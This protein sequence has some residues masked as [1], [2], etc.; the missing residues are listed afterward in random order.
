MPKRDPKKFSA[1]VGQFNTQLEEQ[2]R[3][4]D[5]NLRTFCPQESPRELFK[6][7]RK[8]VE[9]LYLAAPHDTS[10]WTQ[11]TTKENNA[12]KFFRAVVGENV[13]TAL[14]RFL[15]ILINMNVNADSEGWSRFQCLCLNG[16][17]AIT[18]RDL[19]LDDKTIEKILGAR[20]VY[21]FRE[22]Q[23]TFSP[24]V[25][26]MNKMLDCSDERYKGCRLPY[27]NDDH[28]IGGGAYGR[29][30]SVKIAKRHI[31][32]CGRNDEDLELARKDFEISNEGGNEQGD[33]NREWEVT[34]NFITSGYKHDHIMNS[35]FS[36]KMPKTFSIFY[37]KA[38]CNLAEFMSNDDNKPPNFQQK[39]QQLIE[40]TCM[41][42]GLECLHTKLTSRDRQRICCY[43]L[44]LKPQNIL[45]IRN[46]LCED[47]PTDDRAI[48]F[49][50]ADFSISKIVYGQGKSSTEYS[51]TRM[52]KGRNSNYTVES[53]LRDV[54]TQSRLGGNAACIPPE[55]MNPGRVNAS[56]DIWGLGCCL[57]I[58]IAWLY[59]GQI[60]VDQFRDRRAIPQGDLRG[61][62]FWQHCVQSNKPAQ[63][64]TTYSHE[65]QDGN[66]DVFELSNNVIEWFEY[67]F[68]A[69][70]SLVESMFYRGLW[71]LVQ[72]R[73]LIA[74]P[75]HR[76]PIEVVKGQL[77][78][79]CD[80]FKNFDESS[81][82]DEFSPPPPS[83]G[84]PERAVN[85]ND[86]SR[87][88]EVKQPGT[89]RASWKID[90]G[91]GM[92]E[93]ICSPQTAGPQQQHLVYFGPR[94]SIISVIPI[95]RA[96]TLEQLTKIELV[97]IS[98][99]DNRLWKTCAI[100]E[101]FLCAIPESPELEFLLYPLESM[102]AA[103]GPF[104]RRRTDIRHI[105]GLAISRDS[106]K[107]ACV[108]ENDNTYKTL[109][110]ID[111]ELENCSDESNEDIVPDAK[112]LMDKAIHPYDAEGGECYVP[113]DVQFSIDSEYVIVA[114]ILSH[115]SSI[116]LTT[117]HC[118][119]KT[120]K[121]QVQIAVN[122]NM[123]GAPIPSL[124]L[125]GSRPEC[126]LISNST[127]AYV[128][129]FLRGSSHELSGPSEKN[130]LKKF[131]A[132]ILP[133]EKETAVTFVGRR[134]GRLQV[135]HIG[136]NTQPNREWFQYGP[137][138]SRLTEFHAEVD[139]ATVLFIEGRMH[140]LLARWTGEIEMLALG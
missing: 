57:C 40:F 7:S 54:T 118:K 86:E 5:K 73:L 80:Q 33:W 107:L 15:A 6:S 85:A 35:W 10:R 117:W 30:Y 121:K 133:Q 79:I 21:K 44:D 116:L 29:V 112:T 104:R 52:F 70:Q 74:D 96:T 28:Y 67:I 139:C 87:L 111:T 82:S 83:S 9:N 59:G 37:D 105:R 12:A 122:G 45:V 113:G 38:D 62:W 109:R 93:C 102:T 72:Y 132:V 140:M 17:H 134:R 124:S 123:C 127:E 76:Y 90:L 51:C 65:A 58:V 55:A 120:L 22:T 69:S 119:S 48:R 130:Y 91:R 63:V 49:K 98:N 77:K 71:E 101:D 16:T 36:I 47:G 95:G 61:D 100:G 88:H 89:E 129:D 50:I 136:D 26:E 39:R 75:E 53:S 14:S 68:T 81:S 20:Q 114:E 106:S 19:P 42:E 99:P 24:I 43:H 56:A 138:A 66:F 92:A 41:A 103:T 8:R 11:T 31:R 13:E 97:P 137:Q 94:S 32:H 3:L 1:I 115:C 4:E 18:D 84:A 78:D 46:K 27:V 125:F 25:L 128:C 34:E 135:Y 110:I 64:G 126:V 108:Y 131:R 60:A 2:Y 23:Y